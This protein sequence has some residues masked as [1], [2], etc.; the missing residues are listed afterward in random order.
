MVYCH[1]MCK[2][3]YNT[4]IFVLT[5]VLLFPSWKVKYLKNMEDQDDKPDCKSKEGVFLALLSGL[6]YTVM[7]FYINQNDVRVSDLVM[8]RTLLPTLIYTSICLYRGDSL[9][10][11]SKMQKFYIVL[12][13][14]QA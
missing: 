13:G 1:H 5:S 4:I 11:G 7:S 9:L 12:Q 10:P 6:L 8:M 3:C 14:N 2:D